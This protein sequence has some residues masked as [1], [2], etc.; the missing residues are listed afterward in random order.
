MQIRIVFSRM[1]T[2]D[3]EHQEV[4]ALQTTFYAFIVQLQQPAQKAFILH[5]V[6]DVILHSVLVGILHS[7]LAVTLHS[8]LVVILHSIHCF[9]SF[10]TFEVHGPVLAPVRS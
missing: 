3:L 4:F 1:T 10:C 5:S 9:Y 8:I 2:E 7:V 6:L